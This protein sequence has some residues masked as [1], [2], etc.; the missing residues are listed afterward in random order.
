MTESQRVRTKPRAQARHTPKSAHARL[1]LALLDP[2]VAREDEGQPLGSGRPSGGCSL[3]WRVVDEDVAIHGQ[4]DRSGVTFGVTNLFGDV[5]PRRLGAWSRQSTRA[6]AS[7]AWPSRTS[8]T[9]ARPRPFRPGVC[10]AFCG[11]IIRP[12]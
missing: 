12:T 3:L 2:Q 10:S 9:C 6:R 7:V 4:E 5:E 1:E 11:S 8:A